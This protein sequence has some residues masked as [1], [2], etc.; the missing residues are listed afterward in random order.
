MPLRSGEVFAGY[1]VVRHLGD[2]A[3]GTRYLVTTERG[4]P[5]TSN[6]EVLRVLPA[7]ASADGGFRARFQRTA[8]RAATLRHPHVVGVHAHGEH[9]GRLWVTTDAVEGTDADVLLRERYPRGLPP[10]LAVDVV[11]AVAEAL[12]YAHAR[13][14]THGHLT[15]ATILLAGEGARHVLLTGFDVPC[16]GGAPPDQSSLAVTAHHLL[17]GRLPSAYRDTASVPAIAQACDGDPRRRF[18]TCTEFAAAL[19]ETVTADT[20]ARPAVDPAADAPTG[21]V[22]GVPTAAAPYVPIPAWSAEEP[23][24]DPVF[25]SDDVAGSEPEF[26]PT[27]SATA[28][29][30]TGQPPPPVPEWDSE[31]GSG[32][33]AKTWVV[34]GVVAVVALTVVLAVVVTRGGSDEATPGAAPRPSAGAPPS[35]QPTA[36]RPSAAA[37]TSTGV[38]GRPRPPAIRGADPTGEDCEDGYQVDGQGG[39]ASQGVRGSPAATCFFV[40]SVLRAYWNA[41]DP[42]TEPRTVVAAGAIPCSEGAACVGDDFLVTC[43]A[44]GTDPWITCRGGR[45]AVVVLY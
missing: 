40:G 16:D 12:D 39:W 8:D 1:T 35:A 26:S 36:G 37:P 29:P 28:L 14:V 31:E 22:D 33:T 23:T 43:S 42:S 45:D 25:G 24:P 44:E 38:G 19:R 10:E 7:P 18:A 6:R 11:T 20:R 34:A 3:S 4:R 5:G 17:T 13:R 27:M 15:A 41:A 30:D 32:P 21:Y 9:Q 2:D